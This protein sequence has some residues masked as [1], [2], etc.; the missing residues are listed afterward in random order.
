MVLVAA[1]LVLAML[2]SACG[3]ISGA[4]PSDDILSNDPFSTSISPAISSD[5]ITIESHGA[6]ILRAID[7]IVTVYFL[8]VGQA[9]A[10]LV[11]SDGKYMLIDGGNAADSDFIYSFLRNH[12]ITHLDYIIA[13][14]AHED[15][16]GG[17]SG[18]LNYATVDTA[19]CPV[20]SYDSRAFDSFIRY[21]G[22]QGVSIT[23]PEPGDTFSLG[24]A[25]FTILG[26]TRSYENT[27]DSSIIL[28][29]THGATS[30]LFVGDAERDAEQDILSAGYD[31]SA[32][33]LKVGHHGSETS[34]TYP[35]LR[36]IMPEYAVISCGRNNSYGHPHENTLSRFRDAGV[37]LYR[38][39]IQ[40]T[41]TCVSDGGTV[42][43]ST[44]RNQYVETNPTIPSEL[45]TFSPD[46][47]APSP[48][49]P[50]VSTSSPQS[51]SGSYI[52]NRNS[53]KFHRPSCSTLP[54]EQNRVFFNTR[55]EAV[56]AGY[57]AC[58]RCNP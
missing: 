37:A 32:T 51:G 39:D 5:G 19:L 48:E 54:A 3:T 41:I 46:T 44:E 57:D 4:Q 25:S 9:D 30:F 27:N 12:G 47:P 34:S 18:A 6:S 55:E 36:E 8:D 26:P 10:A 38:T 50:S 42:S 20:T 24:S 29:L 23:V 22:N 28:R 52:G 2:I 7:S 1:Q 31:I 49:R 11:V 58:Q 53:H 40:G 15:H 21:L 13:T 56:I 14:H 43:F 16:V 33:V 17:L 45:P 35:F